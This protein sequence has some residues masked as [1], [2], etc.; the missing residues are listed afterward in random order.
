MGLTRVILGVLAL[1]TLCVPPGRLVVDAMI[2]QIDGEGLINLGNRD[3]IWTPAVNV[4]IPLAQ[5]TASMSNFSFRTFDPEGVLFYG[6]TNEGEDWFILS[7][8]NGV[9]EMQIGKGDDLVSVA[10]GRTLN[11]G[12]WHRIQVYSEEKTVALRVDGRR[13]LAMG[14][15]SHDMDFG[16]DGYMRLALGGI[17]INPK[18]IL[19]PFNPL[20]DACIQGGRWLNVKKSWDASR[21][22][23]KNAAV[24]PCYPDIKKGSFFP[25][26][27]L[28]L[29]NSTDL[30]RVD[31]EEEK[32][33][34][35]VNPSS[36]RMNGT[37]LSMRSFESHSTILSLAED[38]EA[39]MIVFK[40][41]TDSIPIHLKFDKDFNS[42]N[43][44]IQKDSVA[45][46]RKPDSSESEQQLNIEG[47]YSN[48]L[49]QWNAGMLRLAFGGML[50]ESELDIDNSGTDYL[51]GC[52]DSIYVQRQKIDL[53]AAFFKDEEVSSYSCPV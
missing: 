30:L 49:T 51:E 37:I 33:I 42:F 17:L 35:T 44:I 50:A 32:I 39:G 47:D 27:G 9:P 52:I 20:L 40:V 22:R 48:I 53:D 24:L 19:I 36:K 21:R 8:R 12:I 34:I 2:D 46:A 26:Y 4:S 7:L 25:G 1:A 45:F 3:R 15:H 5:I 38:I 29:F 18:K 13:E 16:T 14:V 43:V 41:D 11:N 23:R 31:P 10:G 28:A 6:D